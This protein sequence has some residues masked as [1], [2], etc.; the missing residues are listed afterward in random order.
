MAQT[1]LPTSSRSSLA[2]AAGGILAGTFTTLLV[3]HVLEGDVLVSSNDGGKSV[4]VGAGQETKIDER[5]RISTA[6]ASPNGDLEK[7]QAEREHY[8]KLAAGLQTQLENRI[9]LDV[10]GPAE[11]LNENEKLRKK[12]AKLE[13]EQ[14][15]VDEE[16]LQKEGTPVAFPDDLPDA[17]KESALR[18][19]FMEALKNL[20]VAGEVKAIDC[21]EYPCVGWGELTP[22]NCADLPEEDSHMKE[23][24]KR[25]RS[26]MPEG[27]S[28]SK[29]V[30]HNKKKGEDGTTSAKE[31]FSMSPFPNEE[32]EETLRNIQTRLRLRN[33]QFMESERQ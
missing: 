16:R 33:R 29:G 5:G 10:N 20:G 12:L 30:W 1:Q 28:W 24:S 19:M 25:L 9:A 15:L 14:E 22:E 17:Y 2:L 21:S 26:Q 3:V 11:I 32:N 18:E 27:T 7:L 13:H 31:V 8:K 23:L 6:E 4:Q